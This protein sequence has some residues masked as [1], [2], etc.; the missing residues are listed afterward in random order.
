[1]PVFAVNASSDGRLVSSFSSTS[2]Y[3]GQLEKASFF[4]VAEASVPTQAAFSASDFF[5]GLV[6]HAASAPPVATRAPPAKR[7]RMRV[8][9]DSP[10]ALRMACAS[11]ESGEFRTGAPTDLDVGHPG[12]GVVAD[13]R[14]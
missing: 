14:S 11:G 9:R 10:V 1:M 13:D 8:R 7:P 4:S 6:P 2:M 12:W 5:A 3:S